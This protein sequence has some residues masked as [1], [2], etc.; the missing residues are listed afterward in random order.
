VETPVNV[1]ADACLQI[2][3]DGNR[4][5]LTIREVLLDDAG[6]F[7]C[8]ATNPAGVAECSAELFVEGMIDDQNLSDFQIC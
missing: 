7:T 6:I 1:L 4:H 3:R 5:V 2:T 8:R